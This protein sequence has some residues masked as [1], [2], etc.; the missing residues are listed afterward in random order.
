[1]AKQILVDATHVQLPE[2]NGTKQMPNPP[3]MSDVDG[4]TRRGRRIV[5][6]GRLAPLLAA[7]PERSF[8]GIRPDVFAQD[9]L[10]VLL[11]EVRVTHRVDQL[12]REAVQARRYRMFEIDLSSVSAQDAGDP[13]HFAELVLLDQSNRHWLSLPELEGAWREAMEEL[14]A[15]VETYAALLENSRAVE[16]LKAL[17]A[18]SPRPLHPTLPRPPQEV[19]LTA[20]VGCR[21]WHTG[22]GSGTVISQL[23]SSSP[24]FKIDFDSYGERPIVLEASGAGRTWQVLDEDSGT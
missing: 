17:P 14:K 3:T 8:G 23:V 18:V 24:V 22:L 5:H 20:R 21:I 6:A 2:W 15:Q 7:S 19:L 4:R 12:K 13:K 1:M 10:G 9:D 16:P 11:I